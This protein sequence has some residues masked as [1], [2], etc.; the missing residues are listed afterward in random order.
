M[1]KMVV[2]FFMF[3]FTFCWPS[4]VLG[5]PRLQKSACRYWSK[6]IKIHR[7][8]KNRSTKQILQLPVCVYLIHGGCNLWLRSAGNKQGEL[9]AVL[10]LSMAIMEREEQTEKNIPSRMK[11]LPSRSCHHGSQLMT[12]CTSAKLMCRRVVTNNTMSSFPSCCSNRVNCLCGYNIF[13]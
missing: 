8:F 7:N 1:M 12:Q 2:S 13:F 6:M 3:L 11:H 4:T 5:S 10:V 9:L